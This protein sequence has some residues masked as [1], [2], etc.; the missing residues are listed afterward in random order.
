M[1]FTL[2]PTHEV[3]HGGEDKEAKEIERAIVVLHHQKIDDTGDADDDA[4][5]PHAFKEP[6]GS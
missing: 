5:E 1:P 6:E 4:D 2:S 3:D